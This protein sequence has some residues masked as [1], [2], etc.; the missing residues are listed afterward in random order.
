MKLGDAFVDVQD[1]EGADAI[2]SRAY[3]TIS[4]DLFGVEPDAVDAASAFIAQIED[5]EERRLEPFKR[6]I[7]SLDF[8]DDEDDEPE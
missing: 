2:Q 5:A 3:R 1:A 6:W 7:E 8:F 4:V